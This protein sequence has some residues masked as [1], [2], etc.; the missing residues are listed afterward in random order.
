MIY[1]DGKTM[2]NTVFYTYIYSSDQN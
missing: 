1:K 2:G